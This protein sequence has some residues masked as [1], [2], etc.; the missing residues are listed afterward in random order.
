MK[1]V[2][3]SGIIP[4]SMKQ[5]L[6]TQ[7]NDFAKEFISGIDRSDNISRNEFYKKIPQHLNNLKVLDLGCG[8]GSDITEYEAR[9]AETF[10]YDASEEL[11]RLARKKLATTDLQIGDMRKTPYKNNEFD[12]VFSKYAIGTVDEISDIYVE[13]SRV[14][15]S[16]GLFIF[17]TTHPMRLF[18]ENRNNTKNYF[19]QENVPLECFGGTCVITEPSHTFNEFFNESFFKNFQLLDFSE[20]YDPQSASFQGRDIYPDFFIVVAQKK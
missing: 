20:H 11:I 1:Y 5:N 10:G 14:L 4:L 19:H 17:L 12:A 3:I 16:G 2:N 8:D 15:K 18:L 7:Y 9:G 13:V 6:S